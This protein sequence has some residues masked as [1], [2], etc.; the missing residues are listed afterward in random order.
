M[1]I[2]GPTYGVRVGLSPPFLFSHLTFLL[3][4]VLFCF[5]VFVLPSQRAAASETKPSRPLLFLLNLYICVTLSHLA[6]LFLF[7]PLSF[8]L[9]LTRT[10][11]SHLQ[12]ACILESTSNSN[13]HRIE[14]KPASSTYILIKTPCV[15]VLSFTWI[16]IFQQQ[17]VYFFTVLL[18]L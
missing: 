3:R 14:L 11:S 17:W 15:N 13:N 16:F 12:S 10:I 8:V 6:F 4:F 5:Y 7:H 2:L 18:L 9:M 1:P